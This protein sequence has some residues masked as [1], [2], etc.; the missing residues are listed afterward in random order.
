MKKSKCS[1][2]GKDTTNYV[3]ILTGK[4][5]KY[6]PY[7]LQCAR[8]FFSYVSLKELGDL[9]KKELQQCS[10]EWDNF[11]NINATKMRNDGVDF[12][13]L[14]ALMKELQVRKANGKPISLNKLMEEKANS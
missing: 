1:E 8:V 7:C 2:C 12:S 5:W 9:S 13:Q 10:Y 4:D 3:Y 6:E 11:I 14:P